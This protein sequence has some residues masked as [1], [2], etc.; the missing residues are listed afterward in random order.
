MEKLLV[1]CGP[2]ATGKTSLAIHLAKIFNGELIQGIR[3][4][5]HHS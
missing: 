2:T 4:T 1:I 5:E 3:N